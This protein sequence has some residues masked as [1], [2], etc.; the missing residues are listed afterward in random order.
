M[1]SK[2][3]LARIPTPIEPLTRLSKEYGVQLRVKRDDLTGIALS[4]NKVRKLEY[5]LAEAKEQGCDTVIT[6]GA[7]TSNH[8][9]AT[10]IAARKLDLHCYLVLSGEKPEVAE[11]NLQLDLL[12]GARVEYITQDIYSKSIDSY[13]QETAQRLQSEGFNPYVI[14]TGGSNS[15]GL[16]GYVDTVKEIKEQCASENWRP[17]YIYCAVGS[18]G[19]YAGLFLGNLYY[20][21]YSQ[22]MGVLVCGSVRLFQPKIIHDM[23][24][25][26][27]RFEL[28]LSLEDEN[29][30]L[31]DGVIAGGYAKTNSEQIR[32]QRHVAQ[33]EGLILDPVYTGKAFAGMV[34]KIQQETILPD[35]KVLFL[36]TGGI[37]GLSAFSHIMTQE[38]NSVEYWPHE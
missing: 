31:D 11:G 21:L 22:I 1:P 16:M 10:A 38:W 8:A 27:T 24:E 26:N 12:A 28:N 17:D 7:V 33:T 20:E 35:S 37:F 3:D 18:G 29:L 14:P 19:T 2:I 5:L 25:A 30:L 13:L 9:R 15:T 36:H 4:G 23:T 34:R 32:L 6:C